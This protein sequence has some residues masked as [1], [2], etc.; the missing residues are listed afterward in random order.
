VNVTADVNGTVIV[1]RDANDVPSRAQ[2]ENTTV[3]IIGE[4]IT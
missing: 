1:C 2:Q 4:L 3:N